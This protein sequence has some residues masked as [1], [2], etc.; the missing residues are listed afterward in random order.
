MS[1]VRLDADKIVAHARR[2][3]ADAP[4]QVADG[5]ARVIRESPPSR[6]ERLMRSPARRAILDG[7]FWQMPQRLSRHGS[8]GIRTVIEWRITGRPGAAETYQLTIADGR[9][10]TRRGAGE[11]SPQLTITIDGVEFLRLATGSLDPI[12]AYLSGKLKLAGDIMLA[13]RLQTVFRVPAA[14]TRRP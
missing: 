8:A 5:L 9:G 13:A 14:G 4:E 10:R 7:I 1:T 3:I 2:R 6:L 11:A 12:Q